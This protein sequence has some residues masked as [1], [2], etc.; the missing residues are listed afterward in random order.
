MDEFQS[1]I[2]SIFV[3]LQESHPGEFIRYYKAVE[4]IQKNFREAKLSITSD[5]ID[6]SLNMLIDDGFLE[7][8]GTSYR[9]SAMGK[10]YW[11]NQSL[12]EEVNRLTAEV[13]KARQMAALALIASA[14]SLAAVLLFQILR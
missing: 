4:L 13:K 5:Q 10:V 14:I 7:V 11:E 2:L 3:D 12:L 9:L 1:Y 6:E 8:M